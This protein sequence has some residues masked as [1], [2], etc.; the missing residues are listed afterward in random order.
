[1]FSIMPL[2]KVPVAGMLT[3]IRTTVAH[4]ARRVNTSS[5][6]LNGWDTYALPIFRAVGLNFWTSG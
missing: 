3:P 1:M 5:Y 2:P 4:A 6:R